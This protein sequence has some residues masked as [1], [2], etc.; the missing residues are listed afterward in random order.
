L[1]PIANRKSKIVNIFMPGTL[2]IV[3]TPIGNLED[4]SFRAV[5]VLKEVDLIAC[6]D[7]RYTAKL[8][9]HYGITT[10]RESCHEF[11]EESRTPELLEKLR[12]G[13]NI[14][15][16]SDSGTPLISDPGYRLVSSCRNQGI[17]VIPIPG[18]SAAIAALVGSGLPSDSFFFEGFLP[19]R[20]STRRHRLIELANIPA[21]LIFYEAPHRILSC[22]EDMAA[23]FGDREA[24]VAREMTKIHEEF[25]NGKLTELLSLFQNR[26]KIQGEIVLIV[27]RGEAA[28]EPADF[29]LS[30]K[31]HLEEEIKK[32][33]LPRNE[34]LK[35][36]A[37]QR[38]VSRK[39]A[40]NELNDELRL[41]IE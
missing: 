16:V 5:R 35:S 22:L 39:E 11:N 36:V 1:I 12:E 14:A 30:I 21:T 13:K 4:I 32:T 27:K 24:V 8:L 19:A 3:A 37:R 33:G 29:P 34:A 20:S 41:T 40:Y 25:V 15:L 23:I 18:P 17:P 7:T 9:T 38:G 2:Y 10:P 26:P 6:E 31:Q 28:L